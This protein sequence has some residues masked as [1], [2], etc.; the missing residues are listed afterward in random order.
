MSKNLLSAACAAA[1]IERVKQLEV[2]SKA[3]WGRMS[4]TEMLAHCNSCNRQILSGSREKKSTGIK[5]RLLGILAIYI[6]P[7]FVKD[8]ETEERHEMSGKAPDESFENERQEFIRVISRFPGNA[9]EL[10]LS[11]P[12]FGNISTREWGI[13]AY[14]HMDHHL[15]QFGV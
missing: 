13:A 12:A 9:R 2:S 6:A 1:L 10:T 4:V 11:H 3:N 15:R 5:Q 14:K 7:N 8:L